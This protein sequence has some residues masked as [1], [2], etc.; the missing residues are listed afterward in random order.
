MIP[1][2]NGEDREAGIDRPGGSDHVS[3]A[4]ARMH[5]GS[6]GQ[7]AKGILQHS[8]GAPDPAP[9]VSVLIVLHG[10]PTGPCGSQV[11]FRLSRP[12]D[13]TWN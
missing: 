2:F 11:A 9:A 10:N 8:I 1:G 13:K 4:V 3:I 12:L 6:H 5:V 7:L